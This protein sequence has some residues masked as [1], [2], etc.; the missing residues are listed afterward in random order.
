MPMEEENFDR[1]IPSL[2]GAF[3][4]SDGMIHPRGRKGF[5]IG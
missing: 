2:M 1:M 3:L 5:L 4:I